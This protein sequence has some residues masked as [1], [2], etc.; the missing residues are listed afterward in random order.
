M[1][2]PGLRRKVI[3]KLLSGPSF[4]VPTVAGLSL[5]VGG[6]A[7]G[8]DPM[9]TLFAGATTLAVGVGALVTRAMYKVEG[10]TR[11]ASQEVAADAARQ[12]E[13][14]L[15]DLAR[16]LGDDNDPR[17]AQA[18]N[19][20]R[21]TYASLRDQVG[22]NSNLPRAQLMEVAQKADQLFHSCLQSLER[23]RTLGQTA[24]RMTTRE[25][26]TATLAQRERLLAEV[27][28]SVVHL[29]KI[30]DGLRSLGLQ[31]NDA[32][33]LATLRGEL[34]E[35]LTVARRV[36]ERMQAIQAELEHE[37]GDDTGPVSRS[38]PVP[39]R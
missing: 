29:G 36:E 11:D 10:L 26:R 7:L 38:R 14:R 17:T 2:T 15:D 1:D 33:S 18:L 34:D 5:L 35:S 13:A 9:V 3:A 16:R 28:A 31:D 12:F 4:V 23:T 21:T 8:A 20:L 37:N 32:Q 24:Q 27:Q 22:L 39:D 19:D 6:W 30:L 25:V